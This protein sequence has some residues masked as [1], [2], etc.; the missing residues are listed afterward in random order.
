[1]KREDFYN[2]YAQNLEGEYKEAYKKIDGMLLFMSSEL[3][4][5]GSNM[6]EVVDLLLVAQNEGRTVNSVLGDDVY[7]FCSGIIK[8]TKF[9]VIEW[10]IQFLIRAKLIIAGLLFMSVMGVVFPIEGQNISAIAIGVCVSIVYI[11]VDGLLSYLS[12][13]L[14]KYVGNKGK[15][16]FYV[17][18][19][20]QWVSL[21]IFVLLLPES[22]VFMQISNLIPLQMD[23]IVFSLLLCFT[24]WIQKK[25]EKEASADEKIKFSELL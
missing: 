5:L 8:G 2:E 19:G 12:F 22:S 10:F 21:L 20:L 11:P 4:P 3:N 16:F 7:T 14:G 25:R 9:S 17:K 18:V 15:L 13:H 1:M 23:I 24:I 6:S